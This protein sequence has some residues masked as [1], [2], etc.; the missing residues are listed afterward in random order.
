MAKYLLYLCVYLASQSLGYGLSF[1]SENEVI[2]VAKKYLYVR[3]EGYNRSRDI[4]EWNRNAGVE[5]GSP[6]CAS[7]VSWV[8]HLVGLKAPVSAWA[9]DQ[10]RSNN[11][12]FSSLK[13]GDVFGIYFQSKKRV[14]HVGLVDRVKGSYVMTVEANTSPDAVAGSNSD[15]D[16]Q[17]VYSR[18]RPVYLMKQS[19]NKF[20]RYTE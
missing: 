8:N 11:V 9:P 14:A 4:D 5:L 17:G 1:A 6:Y 15:R 18:R 12:P 2:T 20:S 19:G 10:V 3:E 13:S 7:F 16:G